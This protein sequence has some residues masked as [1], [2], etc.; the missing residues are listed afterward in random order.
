M[1]VK[2][3]NILQSFFSDIDLDALEDMWLDEG[4][5]SVLVNQEE[6]RLNSDYALAK[7]RLAYIFSSNEN[8]VQLA[9]ETCNL[10]RGWHEGKDLF[11]A[12]SMVLVALEKFGF[13]SGKG[14]VIELKDPADEP[15]VRAMLVAGVLAE[16]PNDLPY[17]NNLHFRKV[18]L[19]VVRMIAAHN[20]ILFKGTSHLLEKSDIAKLVISACIHDIGHEG[21]GNIV[22]HKYHLAMIEK[23]SFSYAYPYLAAAGLDE[24][25]LEDIKVMLITTDVSP[26]GD[27]ISPVSQLRTAYEFHFGMDEDVSNI[28]EDE[29]KLHEEISVLMEESH[30]CLLC[31]M[32]QEADIMNSA[33]VDYDITRY[34]SLAISEEAGLYRSLPED[35]LL[36]LETICNK[37]MLSAAGCYLAEGKLEAITR[38]VI[39]DYHNGNKPYCKTG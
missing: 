5:L 24:E 3:T 38:R 2:L 15:M 18:L 4:Q 7:A 12:G 27:P 22:D 37:K 28:N 10:V 39:D 34:E 9:N 19:H 30:L 33:A 16:F 1:Q 11:H 32:L 6:E 36:F 29:E 31:V 21:K 8:A 26:I 23:R 14:G 20:N 25:M 13:I 17:H 35:I